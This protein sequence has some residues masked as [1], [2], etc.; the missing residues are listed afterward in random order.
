L[1]NN[2]SIQS[3]IFYELPN[4][5]VR[6]VGGGVVN[7]V[8]VARPSALLYFGGYGCAPKPAWVG[9]VA[10][11]GYRLLLVPPLPPLP[12]LREWPPWW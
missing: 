1:H 10:C 5:N 3:A 11:L 7:V 2:E 4:E 8:G 12:P 6:A 9:V